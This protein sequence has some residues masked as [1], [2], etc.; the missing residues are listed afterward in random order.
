MAKLVLVKLMIAISAVKGWCLYHLDTNNA[1]LYGEL[2][3]DIYMEMPPGM[4]SQGSTQHLQ[5]VS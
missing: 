3:E 2:K 5:Y 4:A 1:F